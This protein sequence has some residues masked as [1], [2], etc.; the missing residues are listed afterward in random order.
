MSDTETGGPD[1]I[2]EF[3]ARDRAGNGVFIKR[4]QYIYS[5]YY[6]CIRGESPVTV[7]RNWKEIQYGILFYY[8]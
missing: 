7:S 5:I 1:S 8:C 4:Q 6:T 3:M 2:R